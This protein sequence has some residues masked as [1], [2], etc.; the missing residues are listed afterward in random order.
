MIYRNKNIV[1]IICIPLLLLSFSGYVKAQNCSPACHIPG[2]ACPP[3]NPGCLCPG[4]PGGCEENPGPTAVHDNLR[5]VGLE[6]LKE[7]MACNLSGGQKQRVAI[8][9]AIG[10]TIK[11][12]ATF[13]TNADK[14]LAIIQMRRMAIPIFFDLDMRK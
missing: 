8:A 1:Y 7:E 5:K 14:I 6:D 12:V 13:S 10:A 2:G 4:C 11:T 3:E 9:R